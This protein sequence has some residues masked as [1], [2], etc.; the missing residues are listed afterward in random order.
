[1]NESIGN[2]S[3]IPAV[4]MKNIWKHFPGVIAN[5]NV[6]IE[7]HAGK[8][9]TILGENGAGKT[10]LMNLLAGQFRPD[11]G[12]ILID[13]EN[14]TFHSPVD[15]IECGIGMVHQHFRLVE[16]LT[17]AENIHLGWKE[18]PWHVT[19]ES[20][21]CYTE[22]ICEELGL[23]RLDC[24]A[25]IWQLSTGEQQRVEIARVLSRGARI[26]ILDEPTAVLTPNEAVDLF[27]TLRSLASTGRTIVLITH[28]LDEVMAISDRVIVLRNG[29]DIA[30]RSISECDKRTLANLMVGEDMTFDIRHEHTGDAGEVI[31]ELQDVQALNDRG[32]PGLIDLNLK[33]RKT[34]I[35][36]IAGVAGNGQSELA[37]I[38]TGL[39]PVEKGC[40][41]FNGENITGQRADQ[42]VKAGVGH[43]PEDRLGRGLIPNASITHNAILREFREPPISTGI[44]LNSAAAFKFAAELVKSADVR[45]SSLTSL[46]H[47]LS[48]GNQQKLLSGRET[49]IATN[50]LVAVHPTRGLDVA[51]TEAVRINIVE[52]RNAGAAVVFISEDLDEVLLLADRVIVMYEGRIAGEFTPESLDREEIGMLMGGAKLEKLQSGL[53]Q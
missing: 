51:A 5:Q 14:T 26:L 50:V 38:V 3:E 41:L 8:V 13:G 24:Q 1:M 25:K 43:I 36:G 9:N 46:V 52:H 34:E 20:L 53:L 47:H 15:A 40:I 42:F 28:K 18:T 31:L 45:V 32:L 30:A 19:V 21:A 7:L 4:Q 2:N 16:K 48:G 37:E 29:T 44:K 17:V 35:L 39:R 23:Q 49:R 12:S 27:R 11:L 22:E 6:N 10:T 33:I